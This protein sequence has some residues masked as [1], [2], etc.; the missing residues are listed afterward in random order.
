MVS[1]ASGQGNGRS[2]AENIAYAKLANAARSP[3]QIRATAE[4]MRKGRRDAARRRIE[5]RWGPQPAGLIE[6]MI[7]RELAG[8]MARMRA[9][10][11]TA[12][13]KAREAGEQLAA[14]E[15]DL[16]AAEDAGLLLDA[17]GLEQVG[18]DGVDL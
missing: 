18:S 6:D 10:A 12:R 11:L 14:A 9:K 15:A 5:E 2:K 1:H 4:A 16:E 13:R 8:Q 17:S 7:D 3:E